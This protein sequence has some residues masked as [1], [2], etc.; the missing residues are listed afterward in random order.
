[1]SRAVRDWTLGA[2]HEGDAVV[3]CAPNQQTRAVSLSAMAKMV[4]APASQCADFLVFHL[5]RGWVRE[6]DSERESVA[7]G[8]VA[9]RVTA[10]T[11]AVAVDVASWIVAAYR[12]GADPVGGL[13]VDVVVVEAAV[14]AD[15]AGVDDGIVVVN[16]VT[17][18]VALA[19]GPQLTGNQN[20]Q[21]LGFLPVQ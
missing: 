15:A 1:M 8:V 13:G 4:P 16:A 10:R 19:Q 14:P 18:S 11:V 7:A 9:N 20:Q 3:A 12:V 17:Y 6:E 5:V 2:D 21:K